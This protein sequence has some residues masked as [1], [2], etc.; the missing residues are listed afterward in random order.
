MLKTA[1]ILSFISKADG[2]KISVM[3]RHTLNDGKTPDVRIIPGQ[4]YDLW[5]R[6]LAPPDWLVGKYYRGEINFF[7]YCEVYKKYLRQDII[8]VIVKTIAHLALQKNI[9]LLCIE[10]SPDYCHRTVLLQECLRYEPNLCIQN[11]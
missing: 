7:D 9:Y 2:L 11:F 4:S 6:D 3:S 5:L 1:S 8:A 10:E